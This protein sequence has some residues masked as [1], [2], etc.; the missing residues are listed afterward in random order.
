MAM[1]TCCKVEKEK[2]SFYSDSRNRCGIRQP[3]KECLKK[4]KDVP[5]S[6]ACGKCGVEKPIEEFSKNIANKDGRNTVCRACASI[7]HKIYSENLINRTE[8][9]LK[10]TKKCCHCG[11]ELPV[12]QFYRSKRRVD[13]YAENCIECRKQ[14]YRN[15]LLKDPEIFKKRWKRY[16]SNPETKKRYS[17]YRTGWVIK[18]PEKHKAACK[19][20]HE[21]HKEYHSMLVKNWYKTENGKHHTKKKSA[22][23][24]VLERN[25]GRLSSKVVQ[26]VEFENIALYGALTCVYCKDPIQGKYHLEHKIPLIRGGKNEKNNLAISCPS[27]NLHKGTMTDKEFLER[28]S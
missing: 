27:C 7:R 4:N 13:G 24:R 11:K 9:P 16:M 8:L 18:N 1:C 19:N 6:K 20:W 21:A 15:E 2:I 14:L 23:R 26:E 17:N 28:A 5:V 22:N 25:A 12:S 10:E 3:C